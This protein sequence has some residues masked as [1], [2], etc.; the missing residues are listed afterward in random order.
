MHKYNILELVLVA[1]LPVM[2]RPTVLSL[3]YVGSIPAYSKDGAVCYSRVLTELHVETP[4]TR[5]SSIEYKL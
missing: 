3:L 1:V 4:T 5:L 2:H